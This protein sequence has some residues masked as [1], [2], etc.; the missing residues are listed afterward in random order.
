MSLFHF[1][2][3]YTKHSHVQLFSEAQN[4]I[5]TATITVAMLCRTRGE[6][7]C[8]VSP[9]PNCSPCPRDPKAPESPPLATNGPVSSAFFGERRERGLQ[10]PRCEHRTGV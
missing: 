3:I 4:L 10:L 6:N 1:T 5:T 2:F 7:H 8:S 9:D